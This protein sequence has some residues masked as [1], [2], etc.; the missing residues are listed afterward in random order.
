MIKEIL[1]KGIE[2]YKNRISRVKEIYFSVLDKVPEEEG[3]VWQIKDKAL[4]NE[5][6]L[7][8]VKKVYSEN[9]EKRL[10]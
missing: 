4:F 7:N 5:I 6:I 9:G 8:F 1:D 10:F 2:N 3:K